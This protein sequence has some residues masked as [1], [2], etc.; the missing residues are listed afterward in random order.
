MASE[1]QDPPT[2]AAAIPSAASRLVL[3]K[4]AR[5][6]TFPV[7]HAQSFRNAEARGVPCRVRANFDPGVTPER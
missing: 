5:A 4:T 3:T 7:M 1:V 6:P 2:N